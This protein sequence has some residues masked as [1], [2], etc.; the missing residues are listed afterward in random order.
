MQTVTPDCQ[1]T[2]IDALEKLE[3]GLIGILLAKG[4]GEVTSV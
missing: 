4:V 3:G 2:L 1:G